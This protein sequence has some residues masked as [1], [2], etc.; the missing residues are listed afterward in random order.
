MNNQSRIVLAPAKVNLSLA[1][2][3][4]RADGFHD[5]Q[6]VFQSISLYDRIE[7]SL[8]DGGICCLCGDISGEKNLAYRAAQEFLNFYQEKYGVKNNVGVKINIQ[9]K[10][11]VQA[12]LGGGSSDAAAVLRTM[13]HLL[14]NPLAEHLTEPLTEE[15][16]IQCAQGC[17]SD[18]A[19]F[20]RGGTQWGE[21]T[22]TNLTAL[23][24]ISEMDLIVVK[25]FSGVR[26][27]DAFRKFDEIGSLATLNRAL[28]IDL[29]NKK[30]KKPIAQNLMNSLEQ[31]A[32]RLLPEVE[33]IKNLLLA[34]GC[35]GA[36]MSG[37]GSA[38]FGI[39]KDKKQGEKIAKVFAGKGFSNTWVVKTIR[40]LPR[41][42]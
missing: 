16:L 32:Y 3:Q 28:W 31:A 11:P 23:P 2:T 10:I 25:P 12:G 37:S 21:G 19:F 29:L 15:E 39:L 36:L 4:K 9:K 22:G 20:I 27:P 30:E 7:V 6:T 33:E 13:N 40:E 34:N 41:I 35:Y 26:T 1:I 8:T 42:V 18:T 38:V 24:P 17:G 14:V 5:I